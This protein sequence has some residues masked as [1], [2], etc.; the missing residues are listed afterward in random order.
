MHVIGD[1]R[2]PV[3]QR[4]T[5]RKAVA[6]GNPFDGDIGMFE[7]MWIDCVQI[8]FGG[9][10]QC[11]RLQWCT[12]DRRIPRATARAKKA[13]CGIGQ[14]R[15]HLRDGKFTFVVRVV[16]RERHCNDDQQAVFTAPRSR[17]VAG[18]EIRKRSHRQRGETGVDASG[19]CPDGR[20]LIGS[21]RSERGLH[22]RTHAMQ[23]RAAISRQCNRAK[24]LR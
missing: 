5:D 9:T 24:Q 22:A 13:E 16:E 4:A 3:G 8:E 23:A 14:G 2:R 12:G 1:Q 21:E 11:G 18:E 7:Q 19:I 20:A 6:A 10:R 17:R 15:V